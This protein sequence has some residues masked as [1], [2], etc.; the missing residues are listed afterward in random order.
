MGAIQP[1][2]NFDNEV[3]EH[4]SYQ[5]VSNKSLQERYAELMK[6]DTHKKPDLRGIRDNEVYSKW[7]KSK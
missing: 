7:F 3:R 1:N 5:P 6:L 4:Q 2:K